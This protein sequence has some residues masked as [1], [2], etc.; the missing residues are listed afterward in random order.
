MRQWSETQACVA[1]S[2]GEAELYALL[3]G[4]SEGLGMVAMA[5]EL[6]RPMNLCIR[7]DSSA[8]RGTIARSGCGR[9]KH[10]R[11]NELWVQEKAATGE[12]VYDK[13]GRERNVSDLLTHHCNA[14]DLTHHTSGMHLHIPVA[15]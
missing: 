12:I 4:S 2:S 3:K 1:L 10:I 9:M 15:K 13:I 7:T 5:R 6:G 8:A 11:I 14:R